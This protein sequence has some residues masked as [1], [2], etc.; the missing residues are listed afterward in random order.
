MCVHRSGLRLKNFSWLRKNLPRRRPNR[1]A[2]RRSNFALPFVLLSTPVTPT[3]VFFKT[4]LLSQA[5][6]FYFFSSVASREIGPNIARGGE[7]SLHTPPGDHPS[8]ARTKR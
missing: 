7:R 3:G 1:P 5:R 6:G 4:P 2:K 8:P